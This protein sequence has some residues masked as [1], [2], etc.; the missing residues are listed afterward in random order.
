[1]ASCAPVSVSDDPASDASAAASDAVASLKLHGAY[2]LPVVDLL[3][4]PYEPFMARPPKNHVQQLKSK[5]PEK[6]ATLIK[7]DDVLSNISDYS[8]EITVIV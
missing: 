2:V 1:M 8:I 3:V 7:K 5:R 4:L 6:K